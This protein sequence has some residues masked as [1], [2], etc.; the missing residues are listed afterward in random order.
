MPDKYGFPSYTEFCNDVRGDANIDGDLSTIDDNQLK[1]WILKAEERICQLAKVEDEW[2]LKMVTGASQFSFVEN[3]P[4][5][6]VTAASPIVVTSVAHERVSLDRIRIIGVA[7]I[8][9]A[10]G[11]FEITVLSPDTFSLA[12]AHDVQGATNAT[13]IV[14]NDPQH[15]FA[16]AS[17]VTISGVLGNTGANGTFVITVIDQDHYSLNTSIGNGTYTG[18]GKI[19]QVTSGIGGTYL[20]PSG[21][22]YATNQIPQYFR[23]FKYGKMLVNSFI[24]EII[25]ADSVTVMD[26]QVKDNIFLL[27]QAATYIY[28]VKGAIIRRDMHRYFMIY[29]TPVVDILATFY[30]TLQINPV[31]FAA[32][33]LGAPIHLSVAWHEAILVFVRSRIAGFLKDRKAEIDYLNQFTAL[34][35]QERVNRSMH[36]R[37]RI[38]YE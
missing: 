21:H 3:S 30:G 10:N 13:P 38:T 26:Q 2:H 6:L 37:M 29:P 31:V 32:D 14:I 18:G 20:A 25:I 1:L 35:T 36:P 7:G 23:D 22:W 8:S 16:N 15:G 12:I 17:T 11:E 5:T 4:I 9:Q 34:V 28:P 27:G 24:Q 19:T 33:N